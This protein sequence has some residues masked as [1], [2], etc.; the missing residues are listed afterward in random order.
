VY[1]IF[2]T[3]GGTSNEAHRAGIER[4]AQVGGNLRLGFARL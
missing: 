1:P 3:I 2:D 4:P